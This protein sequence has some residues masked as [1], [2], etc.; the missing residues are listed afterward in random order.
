[1]IVEETLKHG[2]WVKHFELRSMCPIEYCKQ[3]K[4]K[5]MAAKRAPWHLTIPRLRGLEDE[6]TKALLK[7]RPPC[8]I[9][10]PFFDDTLSGP[11]YL[12]SLHLCDFE[13]TFKAFWRSAKNMQNIQKIS[14][15]RATNTAS[16]L[17]S[18]FF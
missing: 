12:C 13:S 15:Q 1:M 5:K 7:K 10:N 11:A 4:H 9:L 2:G 6:E 16:R 3:S 8:Y 14:G 17:C 18:L